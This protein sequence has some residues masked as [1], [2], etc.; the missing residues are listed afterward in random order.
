MRK[1][2]QRAREGEERDKRVTH[3]KRRERKTWQRDRKPRTP[4]S[5][6]TFSSCLHL[7][8]VVITARGEYAFPRV[9]DRGVHTSLLCF[10][11]LK[12]S[13]GSGYGTGKGWMYDKSRNNRVE[14][15]Q[16]IQ[17][18]R[19]RWVHYGSPKPH[20]SCLFSFV[21]FSRSRLNFL[22]IPTWQ[23]AR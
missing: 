10:F 3:K 5:R 18:R 16:V 6:R 9:Q 11:S 15:T 13:Q 7:H 2:N 1:S 20:A 14:I 23:A 17:V 8:T 4:V 12:G 21:V 19:N 22:V